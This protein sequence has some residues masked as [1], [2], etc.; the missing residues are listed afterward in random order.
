MTLTDTDVPKQEQDYKEV[1][2]VLGHTYKE[3]VNICFKAYVGK[4]YCIT[5]IIKQI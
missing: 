2:Q 3:P 4:N 1:I 5:M